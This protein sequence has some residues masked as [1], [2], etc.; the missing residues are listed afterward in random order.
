MLAKTARLF[1]ALPRVRW[2]SKTKQRVTLGSLP[3]VVNS[4]A[5]LLRDTIALLFFFFASR[6]Q[7]T[8]AMKKREIQ[9]E[10]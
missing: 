8:R 7:P 5:S 2:F 6:D 9:A 1:K 10:A 3:Q 4:D